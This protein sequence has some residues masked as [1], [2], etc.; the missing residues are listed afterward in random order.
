VIADVGRWETCFPQYGACQGVGGVGIEGCIVNG[1][2]F[3]N[4]SN[5]SAE[6]SKAEKACIRALNEWKLGYGSGNM[7]GSWPSNSGD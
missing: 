2:K 7:P 6:E 5:V 1:V 3:K 4:S